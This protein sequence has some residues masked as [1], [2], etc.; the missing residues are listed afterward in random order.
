MILIKNRVPY[1]WTE[2][3]VTEYGNLYSAN[4][5][6]L[7]YK[8]LDCIMLRCYHCNNII[9]YENSVTVFKADDGDRYAFCNSCSERL[10]V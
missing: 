8:K 4:I 7:S 9:S 3:G 6:E 10:F 1:Q 5:G 2:D